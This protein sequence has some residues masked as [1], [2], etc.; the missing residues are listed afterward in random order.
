VVR[1]SFVSP[2]F[3]GD[4]AGYFYVQD[5]S[6]EEISSPSLADLMKRVDEALECAGSEVYVMQET[7]EVIKRRSSL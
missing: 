1:H 6:G 2:R 5:E 3:D 4:A 7:R